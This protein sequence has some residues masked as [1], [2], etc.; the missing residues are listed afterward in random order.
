[1]LDDSTRLRLAQDLPQPEAED[2]LWRTLGIL[3]ARQ[4][5]KQTG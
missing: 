1:M 5:R 3:R 4:S 2:I